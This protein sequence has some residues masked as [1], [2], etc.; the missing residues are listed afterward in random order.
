[1]K[2][3]HMQSAMVCGP[4][5]PQALLRLLELIDQMSS[6]WCTTKCLNTC[7]PSCRHLPWQGKR[8]ITDAAGVGGEGMLNGA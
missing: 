5:Y 6:I 4:W 8:A 7:G 2:T 1:M 3:V